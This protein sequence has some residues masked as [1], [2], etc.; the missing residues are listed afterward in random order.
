MAFFMDV[1]RLYTDMRIRDCLTG[2]STNCL[3]TFLGEQLIELP[4]MVL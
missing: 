1:Q 2:V 4:K 3:T